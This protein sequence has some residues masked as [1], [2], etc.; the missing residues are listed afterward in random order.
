ML[1]CVFLLYSFGY[2]ADAAEIE[3]PPETNP[4]QWLEKG[5][6]Q[7]SQ[8]VTA[9]G[10]NLDAWLSGENIGDNSNETYL[11]IRFNQQAASFDGYHSR[12]KIDGSLDLPQTSK[13]W[14][15]IFESDA[16]ELN[17]LEGSVLRGE[18]S[19]QSI[20]GIS[21]QQSDTGS[22]RVNHSIGFRSRLPADPFYRLKTQYSRKINDDWSLGYR[23]RIWHYKSQGWGYNT[24][25]SF[26]RE[27][28]QGKILSVSSEVRY[29]QDR[30]LTEFSQTIALHN[31]LKQ[32]ETLS[33]ELGV[34]GI[35]KPNVR[36]SD[37]YVGAQYRRAIRDQWLFLEVI[38]QLVVSRDESWRPEPK[39]IINLE[40][41]FSDI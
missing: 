34:L 20:G 29:Q 9:L 37:Y 27:I 23:Q 33:Y 13:R 18:P 25:V 31:A 30:R 16:A 6:S 35:S 19:T 14:K 15:L 12:L 22:W 26:N 28:D 11:R 38:P 21:Y 17:S 7:I 2:S 5:R 8:N 24:D 4:W 3:T 41:Q 32:F 1:P 40:M 10:R 39:L 36:I